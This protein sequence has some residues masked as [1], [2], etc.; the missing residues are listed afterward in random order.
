MLT[1]WG[2]EHRF[3]DR[4]SRRAFLRAGGLGLAGLPWAD[5]PR[6][7]SA[8]AGSPARKRKSVIMIVLPGGPSHIDMYDPKP[9]AAVEIRGEFRPI[10]TKVPGLDFTELM[11]LQ[12]QIADR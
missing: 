5:L 8:R 1:F 11:P 2:A 6:L 9:A 12:A 7:D 10:R 3:C 4:I